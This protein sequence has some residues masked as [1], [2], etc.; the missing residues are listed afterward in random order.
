MNNNWSQYVQTTEE[1]YRSRALRFTNENKELWLSAIGVKDGMS[2]L[3]VGCAGGLFC[4]RIK[5][6]LP[7]SKVTGLDFDIGHIEYAKQKSAELGLDCGFVNGDATNLSFAD[8]TF[9]LC[10]SHTVIEHIPTKPFLSEQFRVLKPGGRIAVLS[11]RTRLSVRNNNWYIVGEG[12]E[13]LSGKLWKKANEKQP[14]KDIAAYEMDEK[15]YPI[16]LEKAGF[17][18]VD[19]NFITVT[20]YAPDNASISKETALEQIN[21]MRLHSLASMEKAVRLA[22]NAL[23]AKEQSELRAMINKRYDDRIEL[24]LS[25]K[26]QWDFSTATV[27]VASGR[28]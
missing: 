1:L 20:E 4:H 11:V 3:E 22:P 18:D 6:H 5:R 19:V 26:K 7:K 12:E 13:V 17:R 10:Y 9:D 23:T 2:V 16:T 8:N 21:C 27:L 15:D 25:D 28:K 24:Y 14:I